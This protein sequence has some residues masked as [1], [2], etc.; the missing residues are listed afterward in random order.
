MARRR[1]CCSRIVRNQ[2]S[3]IT[4]CSVSLCNASRTRKLNRPFRRP[5]AILS[6]PQVAVRG[7]VMTAAKFRPP[8]QKR[9]A[10]TMWA[11]QFS[12]Q[13]SC[14]RRLFPLPNELLTM[15]DSLET[16]STC[17]PTDNKSSSP[18]SEKHPIPHQ[19]ADTADQ[20]RQ[21]PPKCLRA[22]AMAKDTSQINAR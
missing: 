22:K 10:N 4:T 14:A 15:R 19:Q 8:L 6:R 9:S 2:T 5:Y 11:F 21:S 16:W 18:L 20:H 12:V 13:Q 3:S 1:Q 7:F 17:E